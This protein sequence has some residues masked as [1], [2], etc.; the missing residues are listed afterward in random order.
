M[1]VKKNVKSVEKE[2]VKS[3]ELEA[4]EKFDGG[5]GDMGN[6]VADSVDKNVDMLEPVISPPALEGGHAGG[7]LDDNQETG[8]V[9]Q[10]S[11]SSMD[12]E[13]SEKS[14]A[15]LECGVGAKLSRG[16]SGSAVA[17]KEIS[18]VSPPRPRKVAVAKSVS[19]SEPSGSQG[20]GKERFIK[21]RNFDVAFNDGTENG[22]GRLLF[23]YESS[24]HHNSKNI[25]ESV[26][27]YFLPMED[28]CTLSHNC[29][30]R[31][32]CVALDM[33]EHLG[34]SGHSVELGN[35]L[36]KAGDGCVVNS[37]YTEVD[38]DKLEREKSQASK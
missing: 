37:G 19:S 9:I 17:S 10:T 25:F 30:G 22:G 34:K 33:F 38:L 35:L 5:I 28:E 27:D 14:V 11:F 16:E 13:V 32:K 18:S 23:C 36:A 21:F 29:L 24:C 2:T 12:V 26:E 20:N 7:H 1:L 6:T 3:L 4:A 31:V 8:V 15:S